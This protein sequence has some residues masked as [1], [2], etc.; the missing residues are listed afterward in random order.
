MKVVRGKVFAPAR[1][2]P[3]SK[4]SVAEIK[5]YRGSSRRNAAQPD[6]PEFVR[7]QT[8]GNAKKVF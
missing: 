7:S 3:R 1:G 2:V 4:K 5:N 6:K 8:L